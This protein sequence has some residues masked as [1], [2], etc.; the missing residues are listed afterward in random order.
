MMREYVIVNRAMAISRIIMR[1]M[2]VR[3]VIDTTGNAKDMMMPSTSAMR[4]NLL[5]SYQI[6]E[7]LPAAS[8]GTS[9]CRGSVSH[10]SVDESVYQC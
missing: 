1:S 9:F 3:A 2:K 6:I 7:L 4:S 8:P 5:L 10:P